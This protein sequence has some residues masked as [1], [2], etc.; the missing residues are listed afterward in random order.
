M[1]VSPPR[2][3]EYD[4][5]TLHTTDEENDMSLVEKLHQYVATMKSDFEGSLDL[6]ADD[7]VWIN[8]LPESAALKAV[9]VRVSM[10]VVIRARKQRP[11][12]DSEN[13]V[14]GVS[15]VFFGRWKYFF[16]GYRWFR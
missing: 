11:R 5:T 16:R 4:K 7:V 12:S 8:L 1:V 10:L 15:M 9:L 6:L 13:G 3:C 2:A 14:F